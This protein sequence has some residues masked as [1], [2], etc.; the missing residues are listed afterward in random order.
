[1]IT[2]EG[3]TMTLFTKIIQREI[4]ADIVYEDDLCLAFKDINPAAP[5]HLLMIPKK[6]I[7]S[8][9]HA[10]AEDATILSHLLL[11]S[12]EVAKSLGLNKEGYRLVT[13]IGENAGQTVPH[14]H[15]HIL[16]G[17]PLLGPAG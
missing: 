1:M 5:V 2:L 4:P 7:P 3:E 9:D 14:L 17:R 10:T 8:I 15:F 16:G 11:K 6:E 12:A 13:N